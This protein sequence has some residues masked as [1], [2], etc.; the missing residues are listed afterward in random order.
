MLIPVTLRSKAYVCS[1]SVAGMAVSNPAE[2]MYIR[3]LC[4]V[5]SGHV[6]RSPIGH[7]YN[8]V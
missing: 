3:L 1:R 4:C 5:G 7:V 6:Q 8:C 2:G